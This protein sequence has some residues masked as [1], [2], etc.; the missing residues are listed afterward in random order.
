MIRA[1]LA[2][3][4]PESYRA[5][6]SAVQDYLKQSRADV[7]WVPV[8]N[9][10]LTLKF[11]GDIAE[12]QVEAIT[13][14]AT[15]VA[16]AA[17]PFTLGV[18]GVGAFPGPKSPRV[19]WLG[20]NGQTDILAQLVQDLEQAFAPLGFPP[21]NR[22]FVPHLTLGRVR[23]S[24]GREDLARAL[25]LINIPSFPDFNVHGLVLYQSILKPQGAEYHKLKYYLLS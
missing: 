4:L 2:I 14:A 22:K 12:D 24:R 8:G 13:Q 9:I 7:R 23:S 15:G 18:Q 3:D 6:L 21:E 5:G 11:F 20:L 19:I 17:A 16:Q 1:F 10:H 25:Q